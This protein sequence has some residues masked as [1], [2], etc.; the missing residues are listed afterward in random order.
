MRPA[1]PTSLTWYPARVLPDLHPVLETLQRRAEV[2]AVVLFG[3]HARGEARPDSDVD[4]G[5]VLL[6]EWFQRLSRAGAAKVVLQIIE[7]CGRVAR[8]ME[9]DMVVLNAAH[10]LAAWDA[11]RHGRALWI[12]DRSALLSFGLW[13]AG[14]EEDWEHLHTIEM[15]E[16]RRRL[17]LP[18]AA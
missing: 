14:R 4:V 11:M 3:S 15:R 6:P 7:E 5:V 17:G 16:V 1:S 8:H 10:P 13:A 9:L 18:S 2:V 12:R